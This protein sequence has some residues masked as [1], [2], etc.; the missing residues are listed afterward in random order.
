VTCS[1]TIHTET[2]V[3]ISTATMDTRTRHN[4]T[5]HTDC[6][7]LFIALLKLQRFLAI[8]RNTLAN[9]RYSSGPIFG[10]MYEIIRYQDCFLEARLFQQLPWGRICSLYLGK[11]EIHIP[12]QHFWIEWSSFYSLKENATFP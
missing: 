4:F 7:S 11:K 5:L 12:L 2:I 8:Q 9:K 10:F 1:S 6:L 3:W